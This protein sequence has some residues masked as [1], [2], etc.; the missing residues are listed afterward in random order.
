MC[1]SISDKRQNKIVVQ[2]H[3][4]GIGIEDLTDKTGHYGLSIMQ[5]RAE[6]IHGDITIS[7]VSPTGTCV[8][9]IFTP[10]SS[11]EFTNAS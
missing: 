3:D 5:E 6:S 11:K 10:A 8:E 1:I 4:N 9:L 7:R 2:V